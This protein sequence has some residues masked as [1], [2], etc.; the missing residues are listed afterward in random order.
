[1]SGAN[2]GGIML[3]LSKERTTAL[4]GTVFEILLSHPKG[5]R[6]N[7]LLKELERTLPCRGPGNGPNE[8]RK[9]AVPL[10]DAAYIATRGPVKA[11]WLTRQDG[12]WTIT[13]NGLQ[14]YTRYPDP[15][16]L[17][18]RS[19]MVS[20][21]AWLSVNFPGLYS[22][23]FRTRYQIAVEYN[24]VRRTGLRKALGA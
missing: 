9:F 12:T 20:P 24:L 1:M 19:G 15:Q 8:R 6:E 16:Q 21:K 18:A 22:L 2:A 13:E 11:G 23:A 7:A 4:A 10:D 5:M 3:R 14:A 17:L